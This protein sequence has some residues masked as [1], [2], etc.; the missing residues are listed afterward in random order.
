MQRIISGALGVAGALGLIFGSYPFVPSSHAAT[1]LETLRYSPDTTAMLG[2][3]TVDDEDAAADDLA[4]TVTLLGLGALAGETD[5][6]AYHLF[7]NDDQLLSFDT[8]VDLPG[9]VVARPA[10]VV[11]FDGGVYTIEF[12]ADANGIERGTD[13]E[14]VSEI[15]GDLLVSFDVTVELDGVTMY[16]EDLVLFDGA[17]FSLFLDGSD[18]GVTANLALD[19]AHYIAC[20]GHLLLSFDGGGSVGTVVFDD[21]D[22]LE[23]DPVADTWELAY[24]GSGATP[25]WRAADLDATHAT[26]DPGP[27]P[28]AVFGQTILAQANKGDYTWPIAV[29]FEAVRGGFVLSPDVGTYVF[30][31]ETSGNGTVITDFELPAPSNGFWYLVRPGGCDLSSWQTTLGVEPGRDPALP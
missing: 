28:A 20:N 12:D 21:E 19:A 11:R 6:D 4:G 27:G 5:L 10:D 18:A 7:E 29:D 8:T 1:P 24:D 16:D 14:A 13:L 25:A 2:T 15:D 26:V 23:Y 22:V 30:D 3:Q 17:S 9:G 31:A